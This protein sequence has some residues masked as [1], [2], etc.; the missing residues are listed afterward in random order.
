[1]NTNSIIDANV[2]S[3][4]VEADS[5]KKVLPAMNALQA[6]EV[7]QVNLDVS[8]AVRIAFGAL[9]Q[10]FEHRAGVAD[11]M[12]KFDLS[13]FDNLEDYALALS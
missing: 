2:N 3:E 7:L 8:N 11:M 12:P 1:M 4:L 13:N 5:Y 9:P 6:E 10:I